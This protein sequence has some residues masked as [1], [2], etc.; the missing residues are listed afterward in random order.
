LLKSKKIKYFTVIGTFSII[1][2]A[3][4]LHANSYYEKL[5]PLEDISRHA[6]KFQ[7]VE[8]PLEIKET[9]LPS[10]EL[11]K[12]SVIVLKTPVVPSKEVKKIPKI[13]KTSKTETVIQKQAVVQKSYFQ[14]D[15]LGKLLPQSKEILDKMIPTLLSLDGDDYIE[16]EGHSATQSYIYMTERNSK[17]VALSVKNYL[18][19]K[20]K[21]KKIVVTTYGDLYPVVDD[22]KDKR[23]S[24]AELKIRRR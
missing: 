4:F 11:T 13:E 10:K 7:K 21:D 17:Q 24:R 15:D 20:L 19:A 5:H 1:S 12:E 23:N 18:T 22:K 9:K 2:T 3:Y 8:K 6:Q 16:I 14:V